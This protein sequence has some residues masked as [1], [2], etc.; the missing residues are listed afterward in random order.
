MSSK[1]T[2]FSFRLTPEI[3]QIVDLIGVKELRGRTN[4]L[5]FM[6][7]TY[8]MEKHPDIWDKFKESLQ[9]ED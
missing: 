8:A 4:T 6:V 7:A 5:E 3:V 9:P 2:M 1:K